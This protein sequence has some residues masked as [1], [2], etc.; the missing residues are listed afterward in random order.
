MKKRQ[1]KE[2]IRI[3]QYDVIDSTN[4]AAKKMAKEGA[5][6]GTLIIADRQ[7][8]GRGRRGRQWS[9]PPG[10]GIWMSL[11]LRPKIA[12]GNASMLTLVMALSTAKACEEV[13]GL[14]VSIKWPNDIIVNRKKVCGILTEMSTD[15]KGIHY[16]VIGVGVNVNTEAFPED[17]G[18][19]ATSLK[20]ELG[21]P[22]NRE[23]LKDRILEYFF[24]DYEIFLDKEDLTELH[25]DY[26]SRLINKNK[27]VKI[28]GTDIEYEGKALGINSKGELLIEDRTGHTQV[29][30]AG[31]VS[32]RGLYG[33]V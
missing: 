19:V 20:A 2:M 6:N 22:I 25:K 14:P 16:V 28:I 18:S 5:P 10:T 17:I 15:S 26:E 30:Y 21:K 3:L 31:E 29:V 33:Y 23:L 12:A 8:A 11:I 1:L 32:V 24:E 27:E 4:A 13:T 9:S 7:T